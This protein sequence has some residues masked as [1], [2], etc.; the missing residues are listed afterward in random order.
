MNPIFIMTPLAARLATSGNGQVR[1]D[2]IGCTNKAKWRHSYIARCSE[3]LADI[4]GYTFKPE[5]WDTGVSKFDVGWVCTCSDDPH[6]AKLGLVVANSKMCKQHAYAILKA[7]ARAKRGLG[8]LVA[9][10][11]MCD[12][13]WATATGT[14]PDKSTTPMMAALVALYELQSVMKEIHP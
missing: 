2:K 10:I 4:T 12:R 6:I 1:C 3:H 5:D 11:T 7:G 14:N 13:H 8:D 9:A